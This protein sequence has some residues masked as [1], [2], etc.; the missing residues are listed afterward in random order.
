MKPSEVTTVCLVLAAGASSRMGQAKQLLELN[1]Q[2]LVERMGCLALEAGFDAVVVV[3]GARRAAIEAVLPEFMYTVHN[4]NW[5]KGMGSSVH[6]GLS[7]AIRL[8]PELQYSGFILTDQPYLNS[9]LLRNMLRQLQQ[10]SAPG[11][12]AHYNGTLGVPAIFRAGLFPELLALDGHKGAKSILHKY[13]EALQSIPFPGGVF[14]LDFPED[15][16]RFIGKGDSG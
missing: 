5:A 14:D 9:A 6:A 1:G 13:Q 4:P 15:W 16:A 3:T 2:P 11:I 10:G 7:L 12:A 8:F